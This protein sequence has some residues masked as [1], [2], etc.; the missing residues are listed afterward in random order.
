MSRT[1]VYLEAPDRT[2]DLLNIKWAL[3]SA[4]YI[5]RSSWHDGTAIPSPKN[6]WNSGMFKL[7]QSCDFLV[8]IA[9]KNGHRVPELAIMAGFALARGLDVVW[10]GDLVGTI[11]DFEAIQHF[12]DAEQ[13]CRTFVHKM[14]SQPNL[15]IAA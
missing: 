14:Y 4:G 5:I 8:V 6:H 13:F 2:Q 11:S 15:P 9:A 10:I 7:L 12:R 3:K 1:T